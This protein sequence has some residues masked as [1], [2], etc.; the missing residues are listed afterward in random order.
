MQQKV[1]LFINL[2][3]PFFFGYIKHVIRVRVFLL[4]SL[5]T[6]SDNQKLNKGIINLYRKYSK[7]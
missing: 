6:F 7:Y 4:F 1:N 2:L 5:I 3:L